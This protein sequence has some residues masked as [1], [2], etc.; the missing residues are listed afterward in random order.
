MSAPHALSWFGIARLGMVQAGLGAVV[1][2]TTSTM[3]RVMVVELALPAI[4]PGA[5]VALHYAIQVLRPRFGH[6]SDMGGRRTPWIIG[7]MAALAIGAIGAA[8][9]TAWMASNLLA[10]LALALASFT[11]VGL[12]VGSAGTSLLVLLAKLVAPRRRAPAASIVWLLMI[13]G[14]AVTATVAGKLLDPFSGIRLVTVTASVAGAAFVLTV[15]AL[16]HV[17]G[18]AQAGPAAAAVPF[19][20]AMRDVWSEPAS[21]RFTLFVF[22]SMLAYSAQELLIEPFAGAVFRLTPGE[23]TGLN[24]MQHTGVLAGML[25]VAVGGGLAG[26]FRARAMR[27]WTAGGCLASAAAILVL[28]A[29]SLFA[30][31]FPLQAAV[32]A[33]GAAN[34]AFAVS[35]IGAMMG[36]AGAGRESRAGVRMGL[37][38]AAQALAFGA[39]GL[40]GTGASDLARLLFGSPASA[41]AAVFIVEAGL[42]ALAARQAAL[43]FAGDSAPARV[44]GNRMREAT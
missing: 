11:L 35:A 7:G 8:V 22:I 19:V 13:A 1:V 3:N 18:S 2:L 20:R 27:A 21:R 25:L 5:L 30:P 37:W 44:G 43:V 10:G 40:V 28:A 15:A 6:G 38:G 41:Y 17:E 26:E 9:A 34:G 29:S 24:G 12:G 32:L 31:H 4:I 16:W 33:L 42:F 36:L 39:G 23:S 14:I